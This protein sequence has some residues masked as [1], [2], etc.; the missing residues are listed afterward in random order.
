MAPG[1]SPA[2]RSSGPRIGR[3]AHDLAREYLPGPEHVIGGAPPAFVVEVDKKADELVRTVEA[4][5]LDGTSYRGATGR[6]TDPMDQASSAAPGNVHPVAVFDA[7]PRCAAGTFSYWAYLDV[8]AVQ[9]GAV[10][11]AATG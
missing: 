8:S 10:P 1:T 7:V 4:R 5:Y 11:G 9:R 3:W 2:A 6:F